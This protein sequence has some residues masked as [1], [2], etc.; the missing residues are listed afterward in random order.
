MSRLFPL[1]SSS[2]SLFLSFSLSPV[3]E[4]KSLIRFACCSDTKRFTDTSQ[5]AE[6]LD[7][8]KFVKGKEEGGE[9]KKK[10]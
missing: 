7:A 6:L 2:P 8:Q 10:K 9:K 1:T 4:C 3:N 5:L